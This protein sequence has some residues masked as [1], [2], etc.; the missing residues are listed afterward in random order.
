MWY[1]FLSGLS[2]RSATQDGVGLRFQFL[3]SGKILCLMVLNVIINV[4]T[5]LRCSYL[6]VSVLRGVGLRNRYALVPITLTT[7]VPIITLL[8]NNGS[9]LS[10]FTL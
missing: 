8:S 6:M 7:C 1:L 5:V 2:S 4:S 9:V 3:V 10:S